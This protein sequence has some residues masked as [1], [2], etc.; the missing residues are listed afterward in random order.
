MLEK[1]V[2]TL[3]YILKTVWFTDLI[4]VHIFN[5]LIS[6]RNIFINIVRYLNLKKQ[7]ERKNLNTLNI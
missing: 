4:Y 7:K 6:L 2:Y 5:F 3:D 1:N